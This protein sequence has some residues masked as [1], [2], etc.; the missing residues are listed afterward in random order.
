MMRGGENS[1][2]II[3]CIFIM[4]GIPLVIYNADDRKI[5]RYVTKMVRGFKEI[6][7]NFNR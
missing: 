2:D 1:Y 5:Q 6:W 3:T 4:W 7:F